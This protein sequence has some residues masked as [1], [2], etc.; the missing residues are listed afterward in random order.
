M[1]IG[2]VLLLLPACSFDCSIPAPEPEND[3]VSGNRFQ[4]SSSATPSLFSTD[5]PAIRKVI[6]PPAWP[7]WSLMSSGSVLVLHSLAMKKPGG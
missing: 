6:R 4:E 1:M 5:T 2:V 3:G 7:G